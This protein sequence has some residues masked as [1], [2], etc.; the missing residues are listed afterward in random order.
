MPCCYGFEYAKET[1]W[2][3]VLLDADLQWLYDDSTSSGCFW[4]L[5][6]SLALLLHLAFPARPV[7]SNA[8]RGR[9]SSDAM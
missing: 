9:V 7:R 6:S 4:M 2:P 8:R 3:L 5:D 1:R